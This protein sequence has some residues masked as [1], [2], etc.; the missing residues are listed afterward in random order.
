LKAFI[1]RLEHREVMP[2]I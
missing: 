1:E 2:L